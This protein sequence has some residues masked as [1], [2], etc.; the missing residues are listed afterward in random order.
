MLKNR[1]DRVSPGESPDVFVDV[2]ASTTV[3]TLP[4]KLKSATA[5]T[6][7]P[8]A[9]PVSEN[10]MSALAM[11]APTIIVVTT[12]HAL[13]THVVAAVRT[14]RA[15]FGLPASVGLP[16]SF[17]LPRCLSVNDLAPACR[18]SWSPYDRLPG[19]KLANLMPECKRPQIC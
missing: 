13:S 3:K 8:A 1:P 11:S 12:T 19:R 14:P 7:V 9:T 2:L 15:S 18:A 10:N 6:L 4:E 5:A 16:T 17:G